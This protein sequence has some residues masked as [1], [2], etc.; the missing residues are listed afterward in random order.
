MCNAG[1]HTLS[2]LILERG[3]SKQGKYEEERKRKAEEERKS[4]I[5]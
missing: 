5:I 3:N 2:S 1:R 4:E